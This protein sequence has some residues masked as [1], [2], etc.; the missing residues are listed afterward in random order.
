MSWAVGPGK[1]PSSSSP[2]S[3]PPFLSTIFYHG[4]SFAALTSLP[5]LFCTEDMLTLYPRS[6]SSSTFDGFGLAWAISEYIIRH[7]QAPCLFATHFHE[8]TALEQKAPGKLPTSP[9]DLD[10]SMPP[11]AF[12]ILL[13]RVSGPGSARGFDVYTFFLALPPSF[14]PSLPPSLPP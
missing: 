6:S 13:V 3:C 9:H 12:C 7:L 4:A 8:L 1:P 11:F 5:L 10:A 14:P 2:P